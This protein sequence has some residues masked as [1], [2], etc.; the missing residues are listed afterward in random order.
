MIKVIKPPHRLSGAYEN[1]ISIFLAGSI[2]MGIAVDWQTEATLLLESLIPAKYHHNALI[3]NPRRGDWDNSW[4]QEFEDPQFSQQV[5]WE[6]EALR[7]STYKIFFFASGTVSPIS[8]YELGRF[9]DSNSVVVCEEGYQRK[10]NVDISCDV[11]CIT[12]KNTLKEAVERIVD[13]GYWKDIVHRIQ[14][15]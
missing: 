3:L 11:S 2:E 8:L 1:K 15:Y 5:R 6:L 14:N 7:L 4:K 9:A 13:R 10:G 12:Q